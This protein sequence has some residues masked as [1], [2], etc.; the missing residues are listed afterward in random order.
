MNTVTKTNITSNVLWNMGI[1]HIIRIR[2]THNHDDLD[3]EPPLKSAA[4]RP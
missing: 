4:H 1:L 3:L 2:N